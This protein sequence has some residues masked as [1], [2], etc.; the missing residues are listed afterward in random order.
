M[1]QAALLNNKIETDNKT[2]VVMLS[3]GNIDNEFFSKIAKR[4]LIVVAI[5]KIS[6]F[7]AENNGIDVLFN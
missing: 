6:I 3:G 1:L 7:H 2:I 5:E 4:Q